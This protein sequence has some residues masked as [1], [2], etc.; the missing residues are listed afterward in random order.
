MYLNESAEPILWFLRKTA[1]KDGR[2]V[3][4]LAWKLPACLDLLV[5]AVP[6]SAVLSPSP[7]KASEV[8][9]ELISSVLPT[10]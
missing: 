8:G 3:P 2:R 4:S 7:D 5:G 6:K 9:H 1:S 10:P